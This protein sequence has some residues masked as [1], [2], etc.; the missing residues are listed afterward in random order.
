MISDEYVSVDEEK[1]ETCLK[2]AQTAVYL[3]A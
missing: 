2:K 1:A 3:R